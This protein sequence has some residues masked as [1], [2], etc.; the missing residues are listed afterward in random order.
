MSEAA[1]DAPKSN[2]NKQTGS[3]TGHPCDE[4]SNVTNEH[5]STGSENDDSACNGC[6]DCTYMAAQAKVHFAAIQ[7]KIDHEPEH[8]VQFQVLEILAQPPILTR[9]I[10]PPATAPPLVLSPIHLKQILIV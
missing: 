10:K 5:H 3:A 1:H 9:F 6:D 2:H 8:L 7:I 4:P